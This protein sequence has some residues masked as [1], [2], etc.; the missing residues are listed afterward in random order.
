MDVL[1]KYLI[2]AATETTQ[3]LGNGRT[4][5]EFWLCGSLA[6]PNTKTALMEHLVSTDLNTDNGISGGTVNS[7][8]DRFLSYEKFDNVQKYE[9]QLEEAPKME[10]RRSFKE[11]RK[12]YVGKYKKTSQTSRR[13]WLLD[14]EKNSYRLQDH[15]T[16]KWTKK[17]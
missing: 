1:V 8:A 17:T 12:R 2:D 9:G 14:G 7:E 13:V 3:S 4:P 11:K 10:S 16:I 6:T 15:Q 5:F